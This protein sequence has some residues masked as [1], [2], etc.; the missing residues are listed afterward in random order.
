MLRTWR[1]DLRLLERSLARVRVPTMLVWGTL[2]RAVLPGS[3]VTLRDA[4][5]DARLTWIEGAGHLPY[6]ESPQEFNRIVDEFLA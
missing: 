6:E 4:L 1:A 3:A 5:P 2:D